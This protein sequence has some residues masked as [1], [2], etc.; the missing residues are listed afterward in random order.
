MSD[1]QADQQ[2]TPASAWHCR[3]KLPCDIHPATIAEPQRHADNLAFAKLADL[4]G[5]ALMAYNDATFSEADYVSISSLG[6][7]VK[8]AEASKTG[9]FGIGFNS[10]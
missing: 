10:V 7:S 8:R 3:S 6:D 2:N 1:K 4:Q 9:R 5:P